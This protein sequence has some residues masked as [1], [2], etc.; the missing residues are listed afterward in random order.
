ME[1][2][3]T[4]QYIVGEQ[5]LPYVFY[6][7]ATGLEDGEELEFDAL[8]REAETNPP[9]GYTFGHWAGEGDTLE[10]DKCEATDMMGRCTTITAVYFHKDA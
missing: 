10:F 5:F 4:V 6:G 2:I 3:K 1:R 7:D 8:A 9:E